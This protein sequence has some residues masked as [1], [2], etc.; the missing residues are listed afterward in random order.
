M[1]CGRL[2]AESTLYCDIH[3]SRKYFIDRNIFCLL[4]ECVCFRSDLFWHANLR[5]L[6]FLFYRNL[7]FEII[8]DFSKREKN[9]SWICWWDCWISDHLFLNSKVKRCMGYWI[10]IANQQFLSESKI[11]TLQWQFTNV[12]NPM[13]GI[14]KYVGII[15][16]D[17]ELFYLF[18][19]FSSYQFC[20][21]VWW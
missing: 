6:L 15:S 11:R 10:R 14:I 4:C 3:D 1:D 18:L 2:C 19:P 12:V 20:Q 13:N 17:L 9:A 8:G 7:V 16:I 21:E 5:T